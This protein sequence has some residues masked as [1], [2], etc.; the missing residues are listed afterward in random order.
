M[1]R[2]LLHRLARRRLI[3]D[4]EG[5]AGIE[6]ALTAPFLVMLLVGVADVGMLIHNRMDT[7]SALQAGARYFMAGGADTDEALAAVRRSWTSMPDNAKLEIRKVCYCDDVEC[8]CTQNC[9]D[10]SAPA[11]YH[12]ISATAVYKGL[13]IEKTEYEFSESVRIR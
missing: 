13:L 9:P 11:A 10:S 6:F 8:S 2:H 4:S 7:V 1:I 3:R 5:L 12:T